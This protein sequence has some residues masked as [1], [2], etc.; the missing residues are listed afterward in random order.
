MSS[1]ATLAGSYKLDQGDGLADFSD[2]SHEVYA[3]DGPP[4]HHALGEQ[5]AETDWA[6]VGATG[7]TEFG[8]FVSLGRLD[9]AESYDSGYSRLTLARRYL[10]DDDPRI[11]MSA[12]AVAT[13][14][15]GCGPDEWALGAPWLA[16]PWKILAV[17]EA[18]MPGAAPWTSRGQ[19]PESAFKGCGKACL[20]NCETV[21][22]AW[23]VGVAPAL[24]GSLLENPF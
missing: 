17:P 10:D 19:M 6:V 22:T 14:V 5:G 4:G 12:K 21:G 7:N 16:L 23:A 20:D 11:G 8:R 15:A 18:A 2:I 24:Y 9:G 3:I 1:P 13:R